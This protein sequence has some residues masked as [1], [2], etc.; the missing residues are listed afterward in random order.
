MS[1][2]NSIGMLMGLA[3]LALILIMM[4]SY[5]PLSRM[6]TASLTAGGSA[7]EDL[8]VVR[9]DGSDTYCDTSSL[10]AGRQREVDPLD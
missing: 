2:E 5:N 9:L 8:R 10:P 3:M 1:P 6:L 4:G 7:V